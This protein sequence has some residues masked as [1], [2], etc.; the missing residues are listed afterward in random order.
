MGLNST[1]VLS[2]LA[3]SGLIFASLVLLTLL[4]TGYFR[5]HGGS[6]RVNLF[7]WSSYLGPDTLRNFT[8]RTGIAVEYDL[9]DSNEAL[10]AKLAGGNAEYDVVVPSDYMVEILIHK[11]LLTPL[12]HSKLPNIGHVDPGDRGLAH[13]RKDQFSVALV[14]GTT[15]IGYRKDK[16]GGPITSWK[17]LWNPAYKD[18]ILML[19][20]MRECMGAALKSLGHSINTTDPAKIR[21]AR[22]ALM[23]QKPLLRGYNSSNFQDLLVTGDAWIV[24]GYNGQIAKAAREFDFI[25]Y[26]IPREGCTRSLDTLCIPVSAPHKAEA[27]ALVDY[28]LDPKVAAEMCMY[29]SYATSNRSARRFLLPEVASNTAIF[30]DPSALVQ[31]EFMQDVGPV[32]TLFDTYWTEIKSR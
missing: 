32:V 2:G 1:G 3:K 4:A 28:L 16:V 7:I 15:G 21:Q 13:D 29:T 24:Q 27:H 14:P 31:C 25:G 20:D 6:R 23:Q 17:D 10:L 30:P 22:E 5:I 9:Y 19:D 11:G 26:A 12:D 8:D 18:R